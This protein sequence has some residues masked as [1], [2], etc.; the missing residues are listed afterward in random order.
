MKW[1]LDQ[2][3]ADTLPRLLEEEQKLGGSR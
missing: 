3:A 2:L 1:M